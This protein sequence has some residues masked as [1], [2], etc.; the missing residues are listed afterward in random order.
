MTATSSDL[1][2]SAPPRMM[3]AVLDRA[4]AALTAR[5]EADASLLI[6]AVDWAELRPASSWLDNA[7]WGERDLHGEGFVPLA[8]E[9]APLVAEFAPLELA[10][11]L[12]W[13]PD[14]A[15]ELMGDGLELKCRLPRLFALVREL[16]V[17]V[18]V[19]RHV[20]AHTRD[21]GL[22]AAAYAD[23][24]ICADPARVGRVRVEQLVDEARLYFDPDRAVDDELTALASR[25]V[26]LK[27]GRT[28]L[29][30]EVVM[31]LD[32]LDA[33]A[34]DG[35]VARGAAALHQLG[36]HDPL[37]VRRA[38]AVG[39]LADPQR[40]LDL[41]A[42]LEPGRTPA[43]ASLVLHLDADDLD[44]VA[45]DPAVVTVEGRR[46]LGPVLLD[47]LR[48]WLADST[49]V[50]KP[51]LDLGRS[52]AVDGHDPPAWMA[53][54]VRLRDPVCVFP[55]CRR[56]SRGC[57]LDHIEPYLPVDLGGAPGQTRPANLAPLCRTHHRA[58]THGAWSYLR[59]D[60]GSYRWASPS[61][62]IFT[63]LPS[64]PRRTRPPRT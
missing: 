19:A 63:V 9:G 1:T 29:T 40:A 7:G 20:A 50:V 31:S 21:L 33:Q 18:Y 37:D 42:G 26:E 54:L 17:P 30:T 48:T 3:G 58:K 41:F 8:G 53:D 47:V 62:R 23:R 64:P 4:V 6:A 16:V 59:F 39:V 61:G 45:T 14:A 28:P 36:D 55:G 24:L 38:R 44:R 2:A 25:K 22:E 15:R 13:T 12:G 60:D 35:A 34:F 11:T 52:D 32:T 46:E 57:D 5:R 49:L 27:P 51:V 56:R 43:P 10:A